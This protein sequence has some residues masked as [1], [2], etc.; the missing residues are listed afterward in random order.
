MKEFI[1]N[2]QWNNLTDKQR[3]NWFDWLLSH[4]MVDIKTKIFDEKLGIAQTTSEISVPN[5]TQIT[6]FLLEHAYQDDFV[7]E[8]NKI[9]VKKFLLPSEFNYQIKVQKE[10]V[11]TMWLI[12]KEYLK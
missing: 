12:V 7:F 3:S 9:T 5:I 1:D 2:K 4:G 10:F 11:D 6:Q 8:K